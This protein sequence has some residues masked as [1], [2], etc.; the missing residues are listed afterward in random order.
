MFVT[1]D[2]HTHHYYH[3]PDTLT[4]RWIST[5]HYYHQPDT[6]THRWIS[7]HHY[8]HQPDT[9]DQHTPLLSSAR[10]TDTS[11][12]QYTPLL[13]SARHTDTSLDQ[14]TPLHPNQTATLVKPYRMLQTV[15]MADQALQ[16]QW[17]QSS[18]LFCRFC[19]PVI[20]TGVHGASVGSPCT[21]HV[22]GPLTPS[23]PQPV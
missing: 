3:Q 12:D 23:L 9:L 7:T 11:L 14:Y 8:Y 6:L 13:S 21:G 4:H 10:H 18:L 17:E 5:H 20:S 1:R 2:L 19:V 22:Q 16:L 15:H